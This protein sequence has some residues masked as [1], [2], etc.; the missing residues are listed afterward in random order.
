LATR[1]G[2]A[3]TAAIIGGFVGASFLVYLI[4]QPPRTAVVGPSDYGEQLR[5]AID[6]N[7]A[8]I[9]EFST[10]FQSWQNG[11]IGKDTFKANATVA[12]SQVNMLIL[13]LEQRQVPSEW[14]LS[15]SLLIQALE[16]YR[17]Y[18]EKTQE[19]ADYKAGSLTDPVQERTY[20]DGISE[21]LDKAQSLVQESMNAMPKKS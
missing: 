19:Y 6:R 7:Q 5:F 10:S 17:S 2:I 9:D 11:E 1:K 13:E 14:N 15:Y 8:V 20:R 16:N 18:I 12:A 4:P 3:L 21:T